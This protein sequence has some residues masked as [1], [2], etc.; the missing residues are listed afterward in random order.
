MVFA[1]LLH[2]SRGAAMAQIVAMVTILGVLN[3]G[4]VGA[5]MRAVQ[6]R[7]ANIL[8][9]YKVTPITAAPLLIASTIVGWIIFIPLV[10]FL[11]GLAHYGYGMPWPSNLAQLFL[12]ISLGI[13]AFR[14]IGMILA[15]V[16]NSAQESQVM[17]QL[18]Y[19]PML[20]LSGATI[21]VTIL[22]DW[23]QVIAQFL[24]ATHLVSG[25]QAMML[26]QETLAAQWQ[27]ILALSGTVVLGLF[28]SYKLFRWEKEEK[29]RTSAKLWIAGVLLPFVVVGTWQAHTGQILRENRTMAREMARRGSY[30]I[31]GARIFVGDGQVIEV[32]AVLVRDGKIA[33][34]YQGEGP[35]AEAVQAEPIEA[36]G[37]TVLPGLIDTRVHLAATGGLAEAD[38]PSSEAMMERELAA[39]LYSG[40]TAVNR[41]DD[42]PDTLRKVC[43]AVNSGEKLGAEL[44]PCGAGSGEGSGG[45]EQS[46]GTFYDPAL[47]AVEARDAVVTGRSGLLERSLVQQVAPPGLIEATEAAMAARPQSEPA[48]DDLKARMA[49]LLRAYKAGTMLVTGTDASVPLVIHGPAVQHEVELWVRAGI[50]PAVALQAATYN[51]ARLLHAENRIGSIRKGNDADLLIVDGNPLEDISALE[52]ISMVIFKGERINRAGLFNQE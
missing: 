20:F 22:P 52:R 18:I 45:A 6:E 5:G 3:N 44:F 27:A 21:P 43:D 50:P 48:A 51:A 24:P 19:L 7:E 15:A 39:Y 25:M 10:I 11:F 34:I 9:R 31:R 1:G 35:S 28:V 38:Q 42:T 30:L 26:R 2:G 46:E 29:I 49:T 32:G 36:T 47:S 37:K 13:L 41:V 4:L 8:R 23:L 33:A 17:V 14:A 12:F 40:V 16:A